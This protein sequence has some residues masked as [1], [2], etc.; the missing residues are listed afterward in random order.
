MVDIGADE[1]VCEDA[2]DPN[3]WT[4][5]G[6]INMEDFSIFSAAWLSHDPNDPAFD[7]NDPSYNPHLSDP[8]YP[9]E[10]VTD[11]QKLAWNPVCDLDDTSGSAYCIDLADFIA[12][13]KDSP[14][15]WLWE[16]CWHSNYVEYGM[17]MGMGGGGGMMMTAPMIESL[18][19]AKS[20][21]T[22]SI[23]PVYEP[24]PEEQAVAI[25][26]ILDFLSKVLKEDNPV[27]EKG[28]LEM[29]AYLEEWLAEIKL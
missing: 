20:L 26:E 2:S 22:E 18:Y 8:N 24:T 12:F 27:N 23:Q 7:P 16:S 29:M 5:D 1:I 14:Q 9:D 4:A 17:M 10:Y 25:N 6:I 28:I 15:N 19:S 13:C 11:G 3:D 21:Q